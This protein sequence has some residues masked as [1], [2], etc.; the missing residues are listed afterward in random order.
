MWKK[1]WGRSD[2]YM[3]LVI[4]Y[5][6]QCSSSDFVFRAPKA[7]PSNIS[8]TSSLS[9]PCPQPPLP[10]LAQKGFD[11]EQSE[12]ERIAGELLKWQTSCSRRVLWVIFQWAEVVI[13]ILGSVP[14]QAGLCISVRYKQKTELGTTKSEVFISK[15]NWVNMIEK[16]EGIINVCCHRNLM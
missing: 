1:G 6:L 5:G 14:P 11:L 15:S 12:A 10:Y 7:Q 4:S 16:W 9:W 13:I 2:M 8:P 3:P